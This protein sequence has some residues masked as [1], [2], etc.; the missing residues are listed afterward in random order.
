M[1]NRHVPTHMWAFCYH[2]TS[3]Y[4]GLTVTLWSVLSADTFSA[5]VITAFIGSNMHIL[6][7]T[8]RSSFSH[9]SDSTYMSHTHRR[10]QSDG[11]RT[12][13]KGTDMLFLMMCLLYWTQTEGSCSG[14]IVSIFEDDMVLPVGGGFNLSCDFTCLERHH[15]PQ[16]WRRSEQD[17]VSLVNMTSIFPNVIMVLSISS[18]TKADAGSYFC[19]TEPPDTISSSVIIQ[20]ADNL[21]ASTLTTPSTPQP[22]SSQQKN[23]AAGLLVQIW[24]WVLLGKTTILILSVT[25]LAVKHK[26]G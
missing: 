25:A 26:R 7:G 15:I 20:I 17:T 13:R 5:L 2:L 12:M 24:F 11:D 16:L 4:A 23:S 10:P 18:A 3:T 8:Y 9:Q 21:T 1:L 22:D 14:A 6:S 19:R